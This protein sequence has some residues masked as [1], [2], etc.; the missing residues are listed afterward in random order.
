MPEA[1]AGR[2]AETADRADGLP[3]GR[4]RRFDPQPRLVVALRPQPSLA[5]AQSG[6]VER[7]QRIE[8]RD[9]KAGSEIL[10]RLAHAGSD[11]PPPFHD[12]EAVDSAVGARGS[13]RLVG[14]RAGH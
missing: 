10:A 1:G 3:Y 8:L 13:T 11:R 7:P 6:N 5:D 14:D 2:R 4:P 9:R 12:G